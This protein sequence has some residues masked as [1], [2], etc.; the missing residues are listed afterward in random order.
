MT[1]FVETINY[2]RD[3]GSCSMCCQGWLS[4]DIFEYK[5]HANN[6][7]HFVDEGCSGGCCTIYEHRPDMCKE[8]KCVWLHQPVGFPLWMR[9][10]KSK[11]IITE[12]VI[13]DATATEQFKYW[14]VRECGEKIDSSVLNWVIRN[15]L[16]YN[17]NLQYEVGGH[18]D[19]MG[20][21]KFVNFMTGGKSLSSNT[22]T[23]HLYSKIDKEEI[24]Q[25]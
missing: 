25:D 5:M 10:D 4:G 7:C 13:E 9:P 23:E 1:F 17:M 16:H 14:Q 11:V 15:A 24:D 6:P 12:R 19:Y 8:Y 22:I 2:P 18:W 3:C 21:D 20:N